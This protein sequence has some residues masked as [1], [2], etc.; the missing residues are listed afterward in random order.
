MRW[1]S[2][3]STQK[4]ARP[5]QRRS[6]PPRS[7]SI[8]RIEVSF[9]QSSALLQFTG[10][11][12]KIFDLHPRRMQSEVGVFVLCPSNVEDSREDVC[13]FWVLGPLDDTPGNVDRIARLLEE[14]PPKLVVGLEISPLAPLVAR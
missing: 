14:M 5:A 1:M 6:D 12:A 4:V 9:N 11:F 8:H 13:L 2:V 3:L 10:H 7:R